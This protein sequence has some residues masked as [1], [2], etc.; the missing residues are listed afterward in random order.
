MASLGAILIA[1]GLFLCSMGFRRFREMLCVMGLL[2]IGSVTWIALAN[3]R[4][5]S[6]Y[7]MDS[8]TMIVVP[9]CVG[10][11]GAVAYYFLWNIALY[12]VGGRSY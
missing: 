4:P 11:V 1:L 6:G 7:S 8:I 9:V 10:I 2:T 5:A 12:L 3:L